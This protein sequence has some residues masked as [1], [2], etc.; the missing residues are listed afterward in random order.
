VA[1]IY[2]E[3]AT[4]RAILTIAITIWLLLLLLLLLPTYFTSQQFS[5][6]PKQYQSH[7]PSTSYSL[8]C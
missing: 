7:Y 1:K 8:S 6:L 5:W 3:S 2:M 4:L